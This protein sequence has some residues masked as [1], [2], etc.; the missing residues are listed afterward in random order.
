M[1]RRLLRGAPS[2]QQQQWWQQRQQQWEW[3]F[4]RHWRNA[5]LFERAMP[6]R[7]AMRRRL[8]RALTPA[9]RSGPTEPRFVA[10]GPR[11][12][13]REGFDA[14]DADLGDLP[15]KRSF[16]HTACVCAP[17]T[18]ASQTGP[19]RRAR[20]SH[21]TCGPRT[22]PLREEALSFSCTSRSGRRPT[23]WARS[24][25]RRRCS[26]AGIRRACNTHHARRWPSCGRS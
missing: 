12:A 26:T 4:V 11:F 9:Q 20:C 19:S 1:R 6:R 22:F 13:H 3:L 14:L 17:F 8:L 24:A 10:E 2:A 15:S 23:S 7:N 18:L 5:V 16:R 21:R 25:T